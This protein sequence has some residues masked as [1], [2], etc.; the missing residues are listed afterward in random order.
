MSIAECDEDRVV[1]MAVHKRRS[2]GRDLNLEDAHGFIFEDKAV[3]WFRSDLDFN[4]GRCRQERNQQ[5][6]NKGALPGILP[7]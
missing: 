5:E 6:E 1:A 7:T 3:R 2:M 4:R